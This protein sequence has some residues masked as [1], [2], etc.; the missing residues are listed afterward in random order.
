MNAEFWVL[1]DRKTKQ[2][3]RMKDGSPFVYTTEWTARLGAKYLAMKRKTRYTV[4]PRF[5]GAVPA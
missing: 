5:T 3:A 1:I 2:V 4:T